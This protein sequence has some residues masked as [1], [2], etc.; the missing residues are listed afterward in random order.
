[1]KKLSLIIFLIISTELVAQPT[2]ERIQQFIISNTVSVF[3]HEA[4][5]MLMWE[6]DLPV[7]GREEDAAD[8]FQNW[9]MIVTRDYF[10]DDA[11]YNYY[12]NFFHPMVED[13]ADYYY[14]SEKLGYD[15]E[16]LPWDWHSPNEVRYF[17]AL[18]IMADGNPELFENYLEIFFPVK[19]HTKHFP[20]Q[21]K[22]IRHREPPQIR[23]L[24][25][26][27]APGTRNSCLWVPSTSMR[28]SRGRPTHPSPPPKAGQH[29]AVRR[30]Q[31]AP[32]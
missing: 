7:L 5:H 32:A 9:Y 29:N 25:P 4:G 23:H 24:W 17:Q 14:F 2:E 8:A 10:P 27:A 31:S 12:A 18:C 16:V 13:T 30:I 22:F 20:I 26:P 1:M 6:Y 15:K 19:Y 21:N 3:L 11:S 28:A